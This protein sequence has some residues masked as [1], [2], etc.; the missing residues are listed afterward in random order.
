M[1]SYQGR[2]SRGWLAAGILV[3]T[4]SLVR[5]TVHIADIM[6]PGTQGTWRLLTG[7]IMVA[8]GL[9]LAYRLIQRGRGRAT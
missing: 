6:L 3:L 8:I 7:F 4:A 1:A 5:L 9:W 2:P